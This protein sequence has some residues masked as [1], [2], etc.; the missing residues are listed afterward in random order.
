MGPIADPEAESSTI[1]PCAV[2][3]ACDDIVIVLIALFV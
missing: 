2:A 1:P 3:G